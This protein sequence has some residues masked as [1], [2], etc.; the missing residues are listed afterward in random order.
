MNKR[1]LKGFT[2]LELVVVIAIIS[3]MAAVLIPNISD[4][5][6]TNKIKTANDQA[7]QIF[8]AAQDYLVSEQIRGVTVKDITGTDTPPSLCWIMVTTEIGTDSTAY[9]KSN[10]TTVVDSDGIKTSTAT[11]YVA[12]DATNTGFDYRIKKDGT[13]SYPIADG[14]ESRLDDGFKGSWVVA[15]YPKTFT[16]A[17]AVYS[18]Y[19]NTVSECEDAVKLIGTNDG[20]TPTTGRLYLSEYGTGVSNAKDTQESDF[21]HPDSDESGHM[22]TGQ[23]PIPLH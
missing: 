20:S 23:F 17:Y 4:Y 16:V 7:Q 11:T 2:L 12:D 9:D 18:D 21:S 1:K 14:I 15:F 10:K 13:I 6:R 8:M 19:Y 5:L 22:Y 3:I